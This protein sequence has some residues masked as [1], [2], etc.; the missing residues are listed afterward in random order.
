MARTH[1]HGVIPTDEGDGRVVALDYGRRRVGVAASDPSATI[2]SPRATV[3]HSGDPEEPP[4]ELLRLL[5]ELAPALVVVGIPRHMDGS[6]GEMA[7]EAR[8]F[9]RAVAEAAEVT[10]VEW[11]E[12][13]T[14]AAAE[15][16][17]LDSGAPRRKR[18]EKGAR[19]KMA[20]ALLLKS[21]LASRR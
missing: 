6:E 12:R 13:L 16:A 10:V 19:D 20:A 7:K 17:L 18:S 2:A 11:D 3:E 15:Q 14:T 8:S 4:A 1:T 9:G 5:E 21:F